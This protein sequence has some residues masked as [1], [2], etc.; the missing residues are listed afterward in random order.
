MH[1]GKVS[2]TPKNEAK[3]H[4]NDDLTLLYEKEKFNFALLGCV[5]I[6]LDTGTRLT[7]ERSFST[8][9]S[10]IINHDGSYDFHFRF[11]E[12][13]EEMENPSH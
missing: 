10:I 9:G 4:F 5:G 3:S 7:N 12:I 6:E 13:R 1:D 11:G 8:H 2:F